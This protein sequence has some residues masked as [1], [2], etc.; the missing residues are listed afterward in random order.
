MV[1]LKSGDGCLCLEIFIRFTVGVFRERLSVYVY[2]S[3][4]FGFEGG[5]FYL[6]ILVPDHCLS[7]YFDNA[8]VSLFK[9]IV[10]THTFS[11][12]VELLCRICIPIARPVDVGR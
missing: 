11:L 10:F 1:C 2:A 5:A 7:F 9:I 6:I 8:E 12:C 3:V 4:P